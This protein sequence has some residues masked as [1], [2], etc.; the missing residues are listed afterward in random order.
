MLASRKDI[1]KLPGRGGL[2]P[3]S[4]RASSNT[5]SNGTVARSLPESKEICATRAALSKSP[6]ATGTVIGTNPVNQPVVLSSVGVLRVSVVVTT[7]NVS[8]LVNSRSA[9]AAQAKT[10]PLKRAPAATQAASNRSPCCSSIS[11]SVSSFPVWGTDRSPSGNGKC[12]RV[13]SLLA[14][15]STQRR[16]RAESNVKAAVSAYC[17]TQ[18]SS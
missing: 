8:Q 1:T 17:R 4:G 16:T 11:V 7:S 2:S 13:P 5:R 15:N 3:V 18:W 12:G 9:R 14:A 10:P 6:E